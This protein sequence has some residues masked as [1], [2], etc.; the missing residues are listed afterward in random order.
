MEGLEETLSSKMGFFK[1]VFNFDDDSKS[2]MLNIIQYSVLAI[3]PIVL[4]N[5]LSQKYVPE[6]DEEKGS[7][8]ILAEVI[9]QILVMFLGI[10]LVNRTVTYVPTYS[11]MKYPEFNVVYIIL[12]VLMITLSLQTKLGEKVGLLVDRVVELW[13]G[14][15]DSSKGKNKN[16]GKKQGNVRVSQPISGQI[17]PQQQFQ[18]QQQQD[19]SSNTTSISQLPEYNQQQQQQS[20]QQQSQQQPDYNQQQQQQPQ[21]FGP[22]AANE[23]G[24]GA[25]GGAFGG[26]GF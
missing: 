3:I 24:M 8:E 7:P 5:K 26:S 14:K 20:Q 2:E 1:H 6:A 16:K 18:Q 12:A 21:D 15:S 23:G 17:I 10:L 9:I 22:V 25:F 4:L 19:M 13:E 11:G